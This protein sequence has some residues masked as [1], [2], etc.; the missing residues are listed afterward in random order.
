VVDKIRTF[1][2]FMCVL[3]SI[4]RSDAGCAAFEMEVYTKNGEKIK[5]EIRTKDRA[6]ER[7]NVIKLRPW[8]D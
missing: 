3:Y 6:P 1:R 8:S 2:A 5:I 7:G 4:L